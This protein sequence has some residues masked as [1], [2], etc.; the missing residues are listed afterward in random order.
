MSNIFW[1]KKSKLLQCNCFYNSYTETICF[2]FHFSCSN[3]ENRE[4]CRKQKNTFSISFIKYDFLL[5][6][7]KNCYQINT[8]Q[9]SALFY[10]E[11]QFFKIIYKIVLKIKNRN[12]IKQILTLF[13]KICSNYTT[14]SILNF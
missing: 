1:K 3:S 6:L 5:S 13:H 14:L 11:N 7:L 10:A 2:C 9:F 8:Y 12:K 4:I